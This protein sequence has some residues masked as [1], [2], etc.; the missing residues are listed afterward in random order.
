MEFMEYVLGLGIL[1][2]VKGENLG[3]ARQFFLQFQV[4]L[5]LGKTQFRKAN[6][7]NLSVTDMK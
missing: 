4:W 6:E 3:R 7:G 2:R 1:I 5:Q